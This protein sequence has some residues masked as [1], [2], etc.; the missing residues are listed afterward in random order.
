MAEKK[1]M[2]GGQIVVEY[3]IREKVPYTFGIPGH[4][5]TALLDAFVDRQKE[6]TLVP[7]MHE[8]GASHMADGYYRATGQIAAV[9][10]SIGPGAT[11]TLTGVATAF[12]DSFPQLLITG[13]V[14]TYMTGK[15]VLQEI[16]RPHGDNF[17]RMAEPVVKRWWQ[18]SH[19]AQIPGVMT[20]AFNVMLEGRRGPALI[21]LPQDLQAESA[22]VE[23]PAPQTH[24]SHGRLHGDP[25]DVSKAAKLL[26]SAERPVILAGGGVIAAE[27]TELLVAIAE[28]VGA[29]VTTSFMGKGSI[30]EDHPLY[31][32]PCG[33]LGSIP[34]NAMTREADVILSIGC[35][36][37][38]RITSSY[39]P[40][41]T[42]DI[43]KTKLIQVDIDGF[44]IGKNY[45][46]EVGIVGDAKAILSALLDEMRDLA[47][48]RDYQ[49]APQFKRLQGLKAEW[50]EHLRP[51][52]E[53]N[54]SPMTISQ[55]LFEARKVLPRNTIVVTDSSNPQNQV[56]NEFPVYGAKQHITPGGFSGIGFAL[57][58]AIGAK[59]GAPN[60]P[61]VAVCGDGAFLQ[62]G[63]E[64]ATAVM[65][66]I[67]AVFLIINNGGWGAIRNLQLNMFGED[68][69]IIT[70]FKTPDGAPWS[71]HITNFAKSLG[72]EGERVEDPRQIGAAL[73]RAI[74]SGKPY[75]VEAICAIERPYSNMHPTGW[76]DITVP[77][78]LGELRDKYVEGRGF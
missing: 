69:E 67:P 51:L 47:K 32:W 3:L 74:Q 29:A 59:L 61:V 10:S 9:C 37:S 20:Q 52:R 76:W 55:V 16:D 15:G 30:S 40:G 17:P 39:R 4:G 28:H 33:D 46:A 62:T 56:F 1:E 50:L 36:F 5:N 54:H 77:A 72:A 38:D 18:P 7:A 11:N 41:V 53:C 6:I 65:M 63:Q 68:R 58:A 44:E 13:G 31:A 2:T 25:V 14:H 42:F 21:N 43:P 70:G 64:L 66:G 60:Q 23:L 22:F 12:A 75:V 71:A 48:P 27:A 35:R 45:P 78:Y 49:N 8:Q 19:V 26:L 73:Q 34:G 24:R 57:P